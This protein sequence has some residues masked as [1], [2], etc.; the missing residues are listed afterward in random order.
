LLSDTELVDRF[1]SVQFNVH[2]GELQQSLMNAFLACGGDLRTGSRYVS[3]V[4]KGDMVTFLLDNGT[5]HTCQLLIGADGAH[6]RVRQTMH[7]DHNLR[8]S[9]FSCWR[10]ITDCVPSPVL[11]KHGHRMLKTV[12]H[13]LND[14]V[15][16]TSGYTTEDRCFWVLDVTY[17]KVEG[18]GTLDTVSC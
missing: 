2:R 11:A 8:Y 14:N 4:D 17:P 10:G 16:F 12:I 13:P 9:G 6:S 5:E 1:G 3:H 15:S 7:P 18:G